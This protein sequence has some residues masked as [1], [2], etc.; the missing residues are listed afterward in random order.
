M[1]TW[2]T[3]SI[4]PLVSIGSAKFWLIANRGDSA[5]WAG[6][7]CSNDIHP[8]YSVH[9]YTDDLMTQPLSCTMGEMHGMYLYSYRKPNL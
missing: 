1:D 6:K 8:T 7:G 2:K 9:I 3:K 5:L 4:I